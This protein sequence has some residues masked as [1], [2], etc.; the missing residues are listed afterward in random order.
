MEDDDAVFRFDY[1]AAFLQWALQPPG[2][3]RDWHI[4][5]RVAKTKRLVAFISGVPASMKVNDK[6]SPLYVHS[7]GLAP[8]SRST[9]CA[10]TRN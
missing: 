7:L 5:I 6:Y 9:F 8:W 3:K 1:S 4:A 2:W 10:F